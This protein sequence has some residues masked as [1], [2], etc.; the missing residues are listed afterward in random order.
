MSSRVKRHLP[1]LKWL[2]TVKPKEQKAVVRALDKDALNAMHECCV[3]ILKGN[4]PLSGGQKQRLS[5]YKRVLRRLGGAKSVSAKRRLIQ[6][7]GFLGALLTPIVQF[8][9]HLLFK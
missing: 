9:G 8:L 7:G 5:R 4:V 1:L 3:N 2:S 6:T